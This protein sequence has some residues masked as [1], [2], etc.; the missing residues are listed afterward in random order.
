METAGEAQLLADAYQ[1]SLTLAH[2]RGL[3]RI[4]FPSISTGAYGY[5]IECAA[6]VALKAIIAFLRED[7]QAFD[8]VRVVLFSA[9]DLDVY[10]RALAQIH[11]QP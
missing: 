2:Q 3:R 4:A 8:E 5:P 6:P 7:P 1:N 11:P 10:A 9:H